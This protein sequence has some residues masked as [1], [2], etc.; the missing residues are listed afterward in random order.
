MT[1][2]ARQVSRHFARSDRLKRQLVIWA[3]YDPMILQRLEY[4][5]SG[6][7]YMPF[8][9]DVFGLR[10]SLMPCASAACALV[11]KQARGSGVL[12]ER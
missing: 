7:P 12:P 11:A 6:G 9:G 4:F 8:L 5:D 1:S 10:V 3:G 2:D